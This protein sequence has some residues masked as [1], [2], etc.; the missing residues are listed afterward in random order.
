MYQKLYNSWNIMYLI[1]ILTYKV[2]WQQLIHESEKLTD[3]WWLLVQGDE[4]NSIG[5]VNQ[6]I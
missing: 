2:T 4:I 6:V 3:R 5:P 1:T